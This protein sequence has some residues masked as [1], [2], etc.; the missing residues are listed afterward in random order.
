MSI[1]NNTTIAQQ[2]P[3]AA[4]VEALTAELAQSAQMENVVVGCAMAVA[5][6]LCLA[7]NLIVIRVG[8]F[9]N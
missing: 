4:Q 5:S 3:L 6:A 1:I 8:I 2:Q 7:I 9:Y